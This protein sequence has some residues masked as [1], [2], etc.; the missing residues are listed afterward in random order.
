M[1]GHQTRGLRNEL[2][3]YIRYKRNLALY[4]PRSSSIQDI[5]NKLNIVRQESGETL[6]GDLFHKAKRHPN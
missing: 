6:K 4:N 2:K 3:A 1:G 5:S